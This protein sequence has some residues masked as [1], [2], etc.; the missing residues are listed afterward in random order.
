[1]LLAIHG[2]S[3]PLGTLPIWPGGL[4]L[5][6][7]VPEAIGCLAITQLCVSCTDSKSYGQPQLYS[8]VLDAFKVVG[9]LKRL[10]LRFSFPKVIRLH[11]FQVEE[12]S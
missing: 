4:T 9:A 7:G 11:L 8:V 12:L 1:M 5:C 6:C 3:P 2:K 10:C